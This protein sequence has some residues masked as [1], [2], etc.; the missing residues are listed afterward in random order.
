LD[1]LTSLFN[2]KSDTPLT[3]TIGRFAT[4]DKVFLAQGEFDDLASSLGVSKRLFI[5]NCYNEIQDAI[6]E[7]IDRRNEERLIIRGFTNGIFLTGIPGIGKTAFLMFLIQRLRKKHPII[8]GSKLSS[9]KLHY[10]DKKG[11]HSILDKVEM[12]QFLKNEEVY[13]VMDSRDIDS[14]YNLF[15]TPR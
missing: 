1:I 9:D 13:F 7:R 15:F 12:K 8:F 10:W 14:L 2:N 3:V 4:N 5:R 11:N 6:I